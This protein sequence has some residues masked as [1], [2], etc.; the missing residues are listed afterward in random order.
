MCA[1]CLRK[2]TDQTK[3]QLIFVKGGW[4]AEQFGWSERLAIKVWYCWNQS[5]D[6]AERITLEII[7]QSGRPYYKQFNPSLSIVQVVLIHCCHQMCTCVNVRLFHCVWCKKKLL[8]FCPFLNK[9]F[10]CYPQI[11]ATSRQPRFKILIFVFPVTLLFY[12][13]RKWNVKRLNQC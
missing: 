13:T 4:S 3:T 2:T 12:S 10:H 6:H 9:K 7:K 5:R 8:S 11:M 1:V